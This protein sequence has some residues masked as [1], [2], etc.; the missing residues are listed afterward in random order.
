MPTKFVYIYLILIT[1]SQSQP[2]ARN[3]SA[4]EYETVL[5]NFVHNMGFF[6]YGFYLQWGFSTQTGFTRILSGEVAT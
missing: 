1:H 6:G 4:W 2:M 3:Y 5:Y